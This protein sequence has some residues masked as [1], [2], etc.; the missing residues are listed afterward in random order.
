MD[1]SGQVRGGREG[2]G[3]VSPRPVGV[4]DSPSHECLGGGRSRR[5]SSGTRRGHATSSVYF[6][7]KSKLK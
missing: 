3:R 1:R 4:H 7:K 2:P 5:R 6:L